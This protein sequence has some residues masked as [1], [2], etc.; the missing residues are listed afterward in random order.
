VALEL[1]ADTVFV[2]ENEIIYLVF[3]AVPNS[4]IAFGFRLSLDSSRDIPWLDRPEIVCWGDIETQ[5]T[6][7]SERRR[8]E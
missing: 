3:L 1:V 8:R 4:I 2:V 7:G 6:T 5:G